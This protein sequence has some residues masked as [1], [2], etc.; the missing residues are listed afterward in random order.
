[1]IP[2][3]FYRRLADETGDTL[4]EVLI[5]AVLIALI[6]AATTYGLNST[7]R[8][9]AY[10]RAR[11]EAD[12]LAQQAE[13]QLRSEPVGDLANLHR[14][15]VVEEGKTKYTISSKSEYF[16]DSTA[17]SSCN[18][19]T[20]QA[21][22]LETTSTVTW[23]SIGAAKPVVESSVIAPPADAA[24]IVQVTEAGNPLEG[25]TVT[26]TGPSP[27]TTAHTLETSSNGCA[28]LALSPGGYELNVNKP[29]YVDPN[30][31]P[32]THEDLSF[33]RSVYL[34]AETE[35]TTKEAYY[36]GLAG[37][38]KV[39]FVGPA[40]IEEEGDSFVAFNSG[41]SAPRHDGTLGAYAKIVASGKEVYP[42]PKTS[43]YSV[44]AG[45]CEADSP[46]KFGVK[47]E[48]A[49]VAPG[50][51]TEVTVPLPSLK[52]KVMSGTGPGALT[53]GTPVNGA[54]VYIEDQGCTANRTQTT[55]ASGALTHPVLPFGTYKMCVSK[56]G[57]M[58]EE[59]SPF[60]NNTLSGPSSKT[61][62]NG[63]V[64]AE[65]NVIYLGTLP[66]GSPKGVSAGACP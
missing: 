66:S 10:D 55:I 58:W 33:T 11:S 2:T 9:T 59:P 62:T 8:A 36:L 50:G 48:E 22:Y 56:L 16:S 28:I 5:S 26:A 23:P 14:E 18:S 31:Y 47:P 25:A 3:S 34:P 1:M 29:N 42:Y 15:Q 17:T 46:S 41:M 52:I 63:G 12:A 45:T 65:E 24:L 64:I 32:N 7:N 13:D 35:T 37:E 51:T 30:W 44:Y 4:I 61:W 40:A 20:P 57:K 53:E 21:S 43:P 38:L 6:V 54:T 27:G 39:K 49:V 60:E 19:S